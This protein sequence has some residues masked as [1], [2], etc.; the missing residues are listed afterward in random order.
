MT[1]SLTKLFESRQD[2]G[3]YL[4]TPGS[5]LSID[6]YSTLIR[7][8]VQIA[9]S[10]IG[11]YY[12]DHRPWWGD[13]TERHP[14]RV[15]IWSILVEPESRRQGRATEA[16]Q[17]LQRLCEAQ[18]LWLQL[19]ASPIAWQ[20]AK[21]Q[22]SISRRRLI[23]WYEAHG[24][25]PSYPEEGETILEWRPGFSSSKVSNRRLTRQKQGT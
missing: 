23:G 19:E 10:P 2:F 6:G 17:A 3:F 8:P 4:A 13:P 1:T 20:R 25:V 22:R 14:A 18:G 9:V 21:G 11:L 7:G 15:T 5:E 24:F 16:L 12:H